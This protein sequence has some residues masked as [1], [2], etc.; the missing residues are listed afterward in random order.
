MW[1]GR[2]FEKNAES[3]ENREKPVKIEVFWTF[4]KNGSNDFWK[5]LHEDR[6]DRYGA[7]RENR[8]SKSCPVRRKIAKN[9]WKYRF[10]GIFSKSRIEILPLKRQNV[11]EMDSEQ[12]QK[13]AGL[14]LFKK[15]RYI[16]I[17][18]VSGGYTT[19]KIVRPQKLQKTALT[20]FPKLC[21]LLDIQNTRNVTRP[22]FWK[23]CWVGRKSRKTSENRGFLDFSQKRL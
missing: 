3:A 10:F 2:I 12:M 20:I 7:A 11:E 17:L 6:G 19:Q 1:H 15:S 23:K 5:K 14:I 21:T 9:R 13:T 8:T 16:T 18:H 22:D 4:L